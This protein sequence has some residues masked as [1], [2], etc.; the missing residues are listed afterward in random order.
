MF[1]R[2]PSVPLFALTFSFL[3]L[4][5]CVLDDQQRAPETVIATTENESSLPPDT[6]ADLQSEQVTNNVYKE[7]GL[8]P[9]DIEADNDPMKIVFQTAK[10]ALT[11]VAQTRIADVA[12]KLK[13]DPRLKLEIDGHCDERGSDAYNQELSVRRAE[14]VRKAIVAAGISSKR[15]KAQGFGKKRAAEKGHTEKVYSHN[16]RV[17]MIYRS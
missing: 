9:D 7:P 14:A 10:W 5:G 11:D 15:L 2:A 3:S 8:T 17:E 6:D 16:R 4:G 12:S 1:F 13:E